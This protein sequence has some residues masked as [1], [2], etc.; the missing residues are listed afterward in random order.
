[1]YGV[2]KCSSF[3]LLQLVDQFSQH[4]CGVLSQLFLSLLSRGCLVPPSLSAIR[5]V[6]SAYLRLLIS[7][8]A[9]LIPACVYDWLSV[10]KSCSTSDKSC[11]YRS[12]VFSS[13]K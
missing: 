13:I 12:P 2:R 7:L 3:I 8:P 1:M 11:I 10:P 4:E 5:V 9:I 6:S